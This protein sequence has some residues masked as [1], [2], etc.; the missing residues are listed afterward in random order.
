MTTNIQPVTSIERD[1]GHFPALEIVDHFPALWKWGQPL[2]PFPQD[3]AWDQIEL[4]RRKRIRSRS[5]DFTDGH[6]HLRL[7]LTHSSIANPMTKP[8]QA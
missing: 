8:V 5:A 2:T 6:H 3:V 4:R 7:T 1:I